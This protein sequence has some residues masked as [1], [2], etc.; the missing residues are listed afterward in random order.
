LQQPDAA[1]A[2]KID[3]GDQFHV[4]NSIVFYNRRKFCNSCAPTLAERSG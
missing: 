3:C 4:F 2:A 1:S